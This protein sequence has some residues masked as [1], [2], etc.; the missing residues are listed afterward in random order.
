MAHWARGSSSASRFG[1][2][3]RAVVVKVEVV[4]CRV[5]VFVVDS[6]AVDKYHQ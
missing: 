6:L 4:G 1:S 3:K 2:S 5:V